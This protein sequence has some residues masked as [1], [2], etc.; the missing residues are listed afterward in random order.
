[1]KVLAD[2][3]V[4]QENVPVELYQEFMT[5]IAEEIDREN[6]IINDLLT[7]VKLDKTDGILNVESVDINALL[8]LLMKRLRPIA[9]QQNIEV[10]LESNR[11]VQAAVDE[12][13]MTLALSN[14]VE[15]AIKYNK[16][17]GWVRVILDADHQYFMIEVSDSGVGIPEESVAQIYERFYQALLEVYH[18]G[19]AADYTS[20]VF[21]IKH[22][23]GDKKHTG[24]RN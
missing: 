24:Y 5:D 23:A 6:K 19:H 3:L 17:N 13:K 1:M 18:F 22:H 8:E 2:S 16:E 14:L 20:G 7:L 15:N 12:V 4:M 9:R 11:P 21:S 10:I